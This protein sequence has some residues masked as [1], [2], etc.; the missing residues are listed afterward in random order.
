MLHTR[1][2]FDAALAAIDAVRVVSFDF[3]DTL[4]VR[5][6]EEPWHAFLLVEKAVAEKTGY[7]K[8]FAPQRRQAE[9]IA[10]QR[11]W[12]DAAR[13]E[14]TFDDIY[15]VLAEFGFTETQLLLYREIEIAVEK[16]ICY[17]EPY[18]AKLFR[19]AVETG[20]HVIIV[21][22][23]YMPQEVVGDLAASC[24]LTG[25]KA[26]YAS[27]AFGESKAAEGLFRIIIDQ[28][29]ADRAIDHAGDIVHI[30]DNHHADVYLASRSGIRT[31][32]HRKPMER[33]RDSL[34]SWKLIEGLPVNGD[35]LTRSFTLGIYMRYW[36]ENGA[37]PH[38]ELSMRDFGFYVIGPM[39]MGFAAWLH[40]RCRAANISNLFFLARD[41]WLF[42][43]A[44]DRVAAL[45]SPPIQSTYVYASR[46]AVYFPSLISLDGAGNKFFVSAYTHPIA[47]REYFERLDVPIDPFREELISIFGGLE[48]PLNGLDFRLGHFFRKR[49]FGHIAEQ[50][51][52]ERELVIDYMK[53]IGMLGGTVALCDI[54]YFGSM[55]S[56]FDRLARAAGC[57]TRF[58]GFY[59]ATQ[60]KHIY[61]YQELTG[62]LFDGRKPYPH[63]HSVFKCLP[64]MELLFTGVH[65][66]VLG[67][68]RVEGKVEPVLRPLDPDEEKRIAI[69]KDL[70]AGALAFVDLF[71]ANGADLAARLSPA[72]VLGPWDSFVTDPPMAIV[73][74]F[75]D[76]Q[77]NE[78][79]GS[80]SYAPMITTEPEWKEI[81]RKPE[82]LLWAHRSSFWGAGF[83]AKLPE[84]KR[85]A[86]DYLTK[87]E[88]LA[89]KIGKKW[90]SFFALIAK[91]P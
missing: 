80:S 38:S 52:Q 14:V 1:E 21:T 12:K 33:F 71:L 77:H 34:G 39:L 15:N 20:K 81:I 74:L 4:V 10:R 46:R 54:G 23:I 11:A 79:S 84:R 51:Q 32:H 48:V 62:W 7:Y 44:F 26:I 50:L 40:D 85:A 86:L 35:V 55:Q 29:R 2:K 91:K 67:Y 9:V 89:K 70:H 31:L 82:K 36:L 45:S 30:G 25:Y 69:A 53:Q 75:K 78:G 76:V 68:K 42:K 28:L 3:F 19:H 88:D 47:L 90:D 27:S 64:L 41:G 56:G 43:E 66:T 58:K 37:Q 83:R 61:G 87:N 8:P 73:N 17:A 49:V 59:L 22:D 72:F 57:P 16:R 13:V 63:F 5:M 18:N 65:G 6:V 60:D 24:G